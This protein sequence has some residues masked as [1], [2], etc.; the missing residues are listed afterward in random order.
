MTKE[1]KRKR[2][3]NVEFIIEF[4][5]REIR[6]PMTIESPFYTEPYDE[7]HYGHLQ[8]ECDR[9]VIDQILVT[10]LQYGGRIKDVVWGTDE[11]MLSFA[12]KSHTGKPTDDSGH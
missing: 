9:A 7:K 10:N 2:W 8:R 12:S 5:G 6:V 4:C 11:E 1:N 3:L